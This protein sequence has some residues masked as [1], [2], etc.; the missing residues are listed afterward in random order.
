MW[1]PCFIPGEFCLDCSWVFRGIRYTNRPGQ[2]GSRGNALGFNIARSSNR[3][4]QWRQWNEDNSSSAPWP[5]RG[6][7]SHKNP[8]RRKLSATIVQFRYLIR[9]CYRF[10]FLYF[11]FSD[12][13]IMCK[14]KLSVELCSGRIR[15]PCL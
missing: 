13:L 8:H 9:T 11:N 12:W 3:A 6:S 15:E 4:S 7:G 14:E 5:L 2:T 1:K 10:I